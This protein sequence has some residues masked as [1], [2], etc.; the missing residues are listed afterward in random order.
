M[1]HEPF[2][3]RVKMGDI[4][5]DEDADLHGI[6]TRRYLALPFLDFFFFRR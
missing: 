6:I 3:N 1:K 2:M 4:K 5:D